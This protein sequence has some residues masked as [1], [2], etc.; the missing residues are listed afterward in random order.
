MVSP[1]SSPRN[2]GKSLERT[3]DALYLEGWVTLRRA[4]K[5]MAGGYRIS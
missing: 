5:R 4:D 2:F 1:G 3:A